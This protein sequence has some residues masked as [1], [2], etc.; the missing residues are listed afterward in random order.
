[1]LI[2]RA[3]YKPRFVREFVYQS[4]G[5]S[6]DSLPVC[7]HCRWTPYDKDF[8]KFHPQAVINKHMENDH[9]RF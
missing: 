5:W 8:E 9:E 7:P 2:C 4:V 3:L 6:G 1:M